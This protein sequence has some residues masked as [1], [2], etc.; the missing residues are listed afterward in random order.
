MFSSNRYLVRKT[1]TL[2]MKPIIILKK[3]INLYFYLLG[4]GLFQWFVALFVGK[5]VI[6]PFIGESGFYTSTDIEV[7]IAKILG[8]ALSLI[9]LYSIALLQQS[10]KYLSQ[11]NHFT[12]QIITNFK[13]IGVLFIVL[14]FSKFICKIIFT[15]F[16]DSEIH[17]IL[18]TSIILLP[19]IGLF[20]LYLSQVFSETKA[21]QSENEL[22]I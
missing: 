1:I 21:I 11:E 5:Q 7:I 8:F 12:N 16:F 2:F 15:I 9:F 4:I 20:F 10:T 22:T 6:L 13:M 18:D 3:L 19:V 17:F 14:A